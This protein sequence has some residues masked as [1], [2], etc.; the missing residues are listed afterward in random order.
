[1]AGGCGVCSR[2]AQITAKGFVKN[3]VIVLPPD[4]I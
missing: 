1:V 2:L 3:R 4:N